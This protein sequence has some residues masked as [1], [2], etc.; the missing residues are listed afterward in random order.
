M[1]HKATV[2]SHASKN[3]INFT[4]D[5]SFVSVERVIQAISCKENSQ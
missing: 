3:S 4:H 1:K 5:K 2:S